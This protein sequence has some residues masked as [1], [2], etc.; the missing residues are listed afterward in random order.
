MVVDFHYS[1]GGVFCYRM[2]IREVRI[3]VSGS[4][5][6]LN[7]TSPNYRGCRVFDDLYEGSIKINFGDDD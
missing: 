7:G 6:L 1:E 3:V 2:K 5:F 4:D